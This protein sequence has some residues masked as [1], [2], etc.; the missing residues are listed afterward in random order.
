MSQGN[1]LS[2][3]ETNLRKYQLAANDLYTYP[4][5]RTVKALA[6]CPSTSETRVVK[7]AQTGGNEFVYDTSFS[8]KQY[9]SNVMKQLNTLVFTITL[10][11]TETWPAAGVTKENFVETFFVNNAD[12]C[13]AQQGLS[14]ALS[15]H[16]LSLN[17][18]TVAIVKDI[19]PLTSITAPYYSTDD[20]NEYLQASQPD[21]FSD[22]NKYNGTGAQSLSFINALG[23]TTQTSIS[24]A[25]ENNIFSSKI[26]S[27]YSTRTPEWEWMGATEATKS[28]KVKC[29]FW[30]YIRYSVCSTPNDENVIAGVDRLG[31]TTRYLHNS[32]SRLFNIKQ[33]SAGGYRYKSIVHDTSDSQNSKGLLI[34]KL[35]SPPSYMRESM[36]D[37][38]TGVMLPYTIGYP[39][40][41]C[42]AYDE[43]KV[44]GTSPGNF[45]KEGIRLDSV[46]RSIYIALLKERNTPPASGDTGPDHILKTPV[47]FG[48]MKDLTINFDSALT[49]FTD[50]ISLDYVSNSNGYDDLDPLGKL[51]KGYPVKLNVGKDI[52]LPQDLVV[53]AS[54]SYNLTVS[55][56]F[57]NQS[58][59][60]DEETY[61]LYVV[62]VYEATLDFDGTG[63]ML[64]SGVYVPKELLNE[65]YFLRDLFYE[66]QVEVNTVGAGKFGDAM[67]WIGRN[68]LK[69]GKTLWENRDKIAGTVGDVA[70]LIKTVRG[71]K[72][73]G[74][75]TS[76]AGISGTTMMGAG[77]VKN[78]V[79]K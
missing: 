57:Y 74:S 68:A 66:S 67:K 10:A 79:F 17:G 53:G 75:N 9:I 22:L 71:G 47:N 51:I 46:P 62:A 63:F 19:A 64:T 59:S 27:G 77:N 52:S 28:I 29:T 40:I 36:V 7:A 26:Q 54:G 35:L 37:P 33:K 39:R 15:T 24:P 32:G 23:A 50:Q 34:I 8:S 48:L 18:T 43:M 41:V 49:H 76:G 65:K 31:L 5:S 60:D 14:Q 45:N 16:D 70:G 72:I 44:S 1:T 13:Y 69:L 25:N 21:R 78:R 42:Q 20:V 12:I 6:T 56:S 3:E 4:A 58:G 38:K 55:G 30:E 61:K 11:D 73:Q 2:F